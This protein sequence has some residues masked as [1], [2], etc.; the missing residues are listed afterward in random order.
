VT[1]LS[2]GGEAQQRLV[3]RL[4]V[5]SDADRGVGGRGIEADDEQ[6]V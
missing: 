1:R 5:A 6:R 4:A 3:Q 2:L